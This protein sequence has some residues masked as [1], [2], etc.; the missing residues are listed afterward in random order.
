MRRSSNLRVV[1]DTDEVAPVGL[2]SVPSLT[3]ET[4]YTALRLVSDSDDRDN[5]DDAA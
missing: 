3:S 2:I 1:T 5:P 4:P